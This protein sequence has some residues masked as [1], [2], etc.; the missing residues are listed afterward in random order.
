MEKQYKLRELY[1]KYYMYLGALAAVAMSSSREWAQ[2]YQERLDE[3][4]EEI[5]SH[6]GVVP[7]IIDYWA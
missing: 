5:R 7:E 4:G 3:L 1:P 6:G 2:M